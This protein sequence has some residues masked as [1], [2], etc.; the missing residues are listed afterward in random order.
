MLTQI[1]Q[2]LFNIKCLR[3]FGDDIFTG[4][5]PNQQCQSTEGGWLVIQTGLNLTRLTSLCCNNATCM[6]IAHIVQDNENV[7]NNSNTQSHCEWTQCDEAK[8]GRPNLW[9]AQI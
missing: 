5:W 9:A 6:H 7:A 2:V 1:S 8:S 4:W 3:H